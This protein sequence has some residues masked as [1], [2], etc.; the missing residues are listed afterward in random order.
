MRHLPLLLLVLMLSACSTTGER[1]VMG[2]RG[3]TPQLA[4]LDSGQLPTTVFEWGGAIVDSRNLSA[5]TEF[6]ILAYPL[7]KNGRPDLAKKPTGRFIAVVKGY[8]ETADYTTGRQVTLS[9]Q[10]KAIR[11]GKVGEAEYL[12]PVLEANEIQL[13]PAPA[14]KPGRTGVHFGFGAG[15]GGWSGGSIGIGIGF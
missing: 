12:F 11:P 2:E 7:Q 1:P 15:S 4:A 8:L 3:I 9:G 13:W 6:Q 14:E 5:T 10:L